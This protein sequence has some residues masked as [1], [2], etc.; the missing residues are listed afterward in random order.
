MMMN[1]SASRKMK[2]SRNI[3]ENYSVSQR[4]PEYLES[5][6]DIFSSEENCRDIDRTVF[7]RESR[8]DFGDAVGLN[9]DKVIPALYSA[10]CEIH[11]SSN[12]KPKSVDLVLGVLDDKSAAFILLAELKLGVKS[13]NHRKKSFNKSSFQ[14][15][16]EDS[17]QYLGASIPFI[18]TLCVVVTDDFYEKGLSWCARWQREDD[19]FKIILETEQTFYKKYFE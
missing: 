1:N 8:Q 16:F 2:Y 13:A 17:Q 19:G 11:E 14:G 12:D 7:S 3:I 4:F 5:L 10:A 18:N 6:N 15:K 9:G